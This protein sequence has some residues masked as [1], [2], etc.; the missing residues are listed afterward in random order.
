MTAPA[1]PSS[2]AKEPAQARVPRLAPEPMPGAM[3]E[4]E[5]GPAAT[6]LPRA[7][8]RE[9]TPTASSPDPLTIG[10][11][12][13]LAPAARPARAVLAAGATAG[14][15]LSAGTLAPR[16]AADLTFEAWPRVPLSIGALYAGAH[17][18]TLGAGRAV[19]SRFGLAAAAAHRTR[20]GA[21]WF[22]EGGASI[23]VTALLIEGHDVPAPSRTWTLDPGASLLLR[24]GHRGNRSDLWLGA[25]LARWLRP[26]GAFVR[27]TSDTVELPRWELGLEIG[28]R[29]DFGVT[30]SRDPA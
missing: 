23:A 27:G 10:R 2:L 14:G 25:G 24:L 17:T 7:V 20:L 1:D 19:W 30:S 16:V 11:R 15:L 6:H 13:A 9:V 4:P 8:T 28:G 3:S 26:Q 5:P 12:A 18:L 22:V 21:A 29:F